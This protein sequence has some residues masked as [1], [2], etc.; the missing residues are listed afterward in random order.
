MGLRLLSCLALLAGIIPCEAYLPP[1]W[2]G[3]VW[4]FNLAVSRNYNFGVHHGYDH[5]I[6]TAQTIHNGSADGVTVFG[7]GYGSSVWD[8]SLT[9]KVDGGVQVERRFAAP[10]DGNWH[11]SNHQKQPQQGLWRN[12]ANQSEYRYYG[13]HTND[14]LINLFLDGG[15]SYATGGEPND[16]R[17]GKSA[18]L[19]V[20]GLAYPLSNLNYADL[21][22]HGWAGQI[23]YG[24]DPRNRSRWG[25]PKR[26]EFWVKAWMHYPQFLE[27]WWYEPY[28]WN[29]DYHAQYFGGN[30]YEGISVYFNRRSGELPEISVPSG[31][32]QII[33]GT[34]H[35]GFQVGIQASG[36]AMHDKWMVFRRDFSNGNPN[37][38]DAAQIGYRRNTSQAF[39]ADKKLGT[40]IAEGTTESA[41]GWRAAE[42][43]ATKGGLTRYYL[44]MRGNSDWGWHRVADVVD[45]RPYEIN[46]DYWITSP[47]ATCSWTVRNGVNVP[48]WRTRIDKGFSFHLSVIDASVNGAGCGRSTR[49]GSGGSKRTI[50]LCLVIRLLAGK[51]K[52]D[53]PLGDLS[54]IVVGIGS[55]SASF[56]RVS[57][58]SPCAVIFP[59]RPLRKGRDEGADRIECVAP[60][61]PDHPFQQSESLH[62]GRARPFHVHFKR[63]RDL[64]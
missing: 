52:T 46:T 1:N 27:F 29:R 57:E 64:Y 22:R 39:F 2:S 14:T 59:G 42:F 37:A 31:Q 11:W 54:G 6:A 24:L 55:Q 18:F 53:S 44:V 32:L 28:Y 15:W 48:V 13:Y 4:R 25:V 7:N 50:W 10:G 58:G 36:M 35:K 16:Y 34:Q 49:R 20:P 17:N 63:R 47:D 60:A 41:S 33:K 8:I 56:H 3:L 5:F 62:R 26:A 19:W 45:V 30:P 51:R 43:T 12:A 23:S 61:H 9:L 21:Q 40:K 38:S